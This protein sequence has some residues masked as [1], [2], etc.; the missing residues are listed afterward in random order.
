MVLNFQKWEKWREIVQIHVIIIASIS[1]TEKGMQYES[2]IW[3]LE[4]TQ[5]ATS[6]F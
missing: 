1:D 5:K 4:I 2:P 3:I 6:A